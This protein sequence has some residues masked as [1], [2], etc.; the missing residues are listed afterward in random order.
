MVELLGER[1]KAI[2]TDRITSGVSSACS[3]RNTGIEW[4]GQI[5]SH[6]E[7]YPLRLL[8]WYQEGAGIMA[9]DFHDEGVPLLRV[10]NLVGDTVE[11][12]GCNYL[13]PAK[14]SKRWAHFR[15]DAACLQSGTEY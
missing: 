2:I 3:V 11:L 1:R 12:E 9:E 5:P 13:D 7:I 10:R 14:V 6:W 15:L 4:I 8:I